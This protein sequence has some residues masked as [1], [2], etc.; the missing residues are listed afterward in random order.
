[1]V[2]WLIDSGST[3]I[4]LSAY[5]RIMATFLVMKGLIVGVIMEQENKEVGDEERVKA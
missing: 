3:A 1:V 4:Q 5:D 2:E